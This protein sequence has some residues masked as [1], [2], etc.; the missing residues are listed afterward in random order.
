[1]DLFIR[2]VSSKSHKATLQ[3]L[4]GLPI[5]ATESGKGALILSTLTSI[6]N[7][8][9]NLTEQVNSVVLLMSDALVV[10]TA[11]IVNLS[12]HLL[13]TVFGTVQGVSPGGFVCRATHFDSFTAGHI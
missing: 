13:Y 7:E 11:F 5:A 9:V 1:M 10:K 4:W 2:S 6:T 8:F 3:N 12:A